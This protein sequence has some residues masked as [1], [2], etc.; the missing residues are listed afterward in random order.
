MTTKDELNKAGQMMPGWTTIKVLE[1]NA[2]RKVAGFLAA[3]ND[4]LGKL[5][6][7]RRFR[8]WPEEKPERSGQF[9]CRITL[10][11]IRYWCVCDWNGDEWCESN[12][13]TESEITV[14]HWWPLP[15]VLDETTCC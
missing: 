13:M 4:A 9:I 3:E 12:T 15:E 11:G 5:L 14:T 7:A 6:L 1:L 2:L 8:K 10:N